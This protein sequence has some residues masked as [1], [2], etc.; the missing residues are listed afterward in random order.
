MT[1]DQIFWIFGYLQL[2]DW[3]DSDN[4][5]LFSGLLGVNDSGITTKR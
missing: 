5:E 1:D 3:F 4:A 2:R